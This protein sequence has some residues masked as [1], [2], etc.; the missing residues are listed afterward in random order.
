MPPVG[1]TEQPVFHAPLVAKT[2]SVGGYGFARNRSLHP[3]RRAGRVGPAGGVEPGGP[4]FLVIQHV[5]MLVG[6]Q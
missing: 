3:P 1:Y 6:V 2:A 4:S 5:A